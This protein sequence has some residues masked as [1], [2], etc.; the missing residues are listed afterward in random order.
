MTRTVIG[1]RGLTKVYSLGS[2][3]HR[4][5]INALDDVTFEVKSDRPVVVSLIGES[6]SGKTT[7]AKVLLRLVDPNAG[8]LE[9]EG[10]PIVSDLPGPTPSTPGAC[11][12]A[13]PDL[14]KPVRGV[15]C[16][17][18]SGLLPQGYRDVHQQGQGRG[19]GRNANR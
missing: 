12:R 16:L 11:D 18:E 15:Q 6:G 19:G 1:V 2:F 5:R 14:P 9:V 3:F 4:I 7:L 8:R 17:P 13:R 10:Q